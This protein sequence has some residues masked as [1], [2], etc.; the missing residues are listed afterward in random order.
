M[1]WIKDAKATALG[2]DAQRAYTEGRTTFTARL[3]TP[4]T[5]SGTSGPVPGWAEMIEAV[6]A[7]GWGLTHW[8]VTDGDK[9]RPTAYAVFRRR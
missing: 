1:G 9:A 7:A 5:S 3:N 8:A 4:A 2:D 6:E